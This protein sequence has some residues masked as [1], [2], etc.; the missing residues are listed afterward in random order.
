M[1]LKVEEAREVKVALWNVVGAKWRKC[2][3]FVTLISNR[4]MSLLTKQKQY[5]GQN[6]SYRKPIHTLG[7]K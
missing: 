7:D 6:V 5:I 3:S 1:A 4:R 2:A